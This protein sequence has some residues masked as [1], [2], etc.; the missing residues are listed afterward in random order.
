MLRP[1]QAGPRN[2]TTESTH[3]R[4]VNVGLGHSNPLGSMG[5]LA[6]DGQGY[7]PESFSGARP[8]ARS[9]GTGGVAAVNGTSNNWTSIAAVPQP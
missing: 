4:H 9:F 3:H 2:R 5:E 6:A 7:P 1:S 8:S